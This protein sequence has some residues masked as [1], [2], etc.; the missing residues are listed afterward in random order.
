MTVDIKL[1]S[2][3]ELN[4]ASFKWQ[5]KQGINSSSMK[6]LNDEF[7]HYRGL[8]PL[9]IFITGPPCSGKTHFGKKLCELYGVPHY[10]INDIVQ[11]GYKL[12]GGFAETMKARVEELKDEAEA[13]YEKSRKKKDPDFNR[14]AFMPRLPDDVI[15]ELVK[16]Q[17][18]SAGCMNKGYILEGFPRSPED[19][20][21]TFSPEDAALICPQYAICIDAED[22][23]LT[24]KAKDLSPEVLN[25][26]QHWN[27]AGM[28]RR[29]KAHRERMEGENGSVKDYFLKKL[30]HQN[31]L[32]VD[33]MSPE[34]E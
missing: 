32:D 6:L 21:A 12:E 30:G 22:A 3:P 20:E 4:D 10:N 25:E 15:N 28:A 9:K 14:D 24:Q 7:N 18:N 5:C 31:V 23:D 16:I 33:A 34:E 8:F 17:L 19:A 13:E 11:M 29:L 26:C 1:S 27:D 2:S